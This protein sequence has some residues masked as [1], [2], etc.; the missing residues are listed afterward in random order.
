MLRKHEAAGSN[1]VLSMNGFF[2]E[3]AGPATERC[4]VDGDALRSGAESNP[5]LSMPGMVAV[6]S[7]G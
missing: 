7:L 2:R 4:E 1:P 5:V 6:L 3:A